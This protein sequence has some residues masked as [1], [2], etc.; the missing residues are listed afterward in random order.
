MVQN[1]K[2]IFWDVCGSRI[3][4][5]FFPALPRGREPTFAK[6]ST[7]FTLANGF[8]EWH[9]GGW[10]VICVPKIMRSSETH[11]HVERVFIWT[12]AVNEVQKP[13][14][15]VLQNMLPSKLKLIWYMRDQEYLGRN[16]LHNPPCDSQEVS[17]HSC[18]DWHGDVLEWDHN[19]LESRFSR[20]AVIPGRDVQRYISR[21]GQW[22]HVGWGGAMGM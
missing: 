11:R 12:K 6:T 1:C 22:R 8:I 3:G 17:L 15:L 13:S 10:E 16:L 14:R 5:W 20:L 7:R 19:N 21:Y 9:Q 18:C 2:E 4:F